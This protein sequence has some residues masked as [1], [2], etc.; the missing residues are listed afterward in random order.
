M[1]PDLV[2]FQVQKL[3][4]DL[5]N[6]VVRE[7]QDDGA[8]RPILFVA[9]SLGGLLVKAVGFSLHTPTFLTCRLLKI[10]RP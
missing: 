3:A 5:V 4:E 2:Q 6:D 8:E 9:H 10:G 1:T 7:R